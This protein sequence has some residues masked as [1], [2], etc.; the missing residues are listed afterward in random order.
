MFAW[1]WDCARGAIVLKELKALAAAGDMEGFTSA[2]RKWDAVRSVKCAKLSMLELSLQ[3]HD[4]LPDAKAVVLHRVLTT[5]AEAGQ[6]DIVKCLI[7]QH[8]C[9]V[10][11]AAV[12]AA[13]K[14]EQWA[15]LELFLEKGWDINSP[16][17]GNNTYSILKYVTSLTIIIL[18]SI[19]I[20]FYGFYTNSSPIERCSAQKHSPDGVSTMAQIPPAERPRGITMSRVWPGAGRHC[21]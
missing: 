11:P 14:C 1:F 16:V 12:R 18:S 9:I 19:A 5:A 17:L 2:M 3:C 10:C 6:V 13:F 7:E 15:I 20:S 8:G 4:C 21:R